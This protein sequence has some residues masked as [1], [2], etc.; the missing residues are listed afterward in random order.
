MGY[1]AYVRQIYLD[2]EHY[3]L[4]K[5]AYAK[6]PSGMQ[7]PD[8]DRALEGVLDSPAHSAARQSPGGN[9]PHAA[10]RAPS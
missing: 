9:R 10:L 1:I 7:R 3:K 2:A 4:V 5:D 6:N 8:Y